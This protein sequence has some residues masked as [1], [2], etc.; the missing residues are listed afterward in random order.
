[1][2]LYHFTRR[3]NAVL[4][5]QHGINPGKFPGGES[6]N[7]KL[8]S[9]TSRLSPVGHGLFRG[10]ALYEGTRAFD[11]VSGIFPELVVG[12]LPN[13][14]MKMF[15]QTEV[16]IEVE[17]PLVDQNLWGLW[18]FA[19]Q[20]VPLLES[21]EQDL[22]ISASLASADFPCNDA[23]N[24]RLDAR[25][26]FYRPLVRAGLINNRGWHFYKGAVAPALINRVLYRQPDGSYAQ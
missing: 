2:I 21:A 4:I 1:M 7:F 14:S 25:T 20:V 6:A 17:I 19:S 22:F 12:K 8:V 16:A 15:D 24:A 18:Y 3:Q 26:I 10:E 9:L 11:V 23:C 13:R 5:K